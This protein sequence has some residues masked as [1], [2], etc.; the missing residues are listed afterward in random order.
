MLNLIIEKIFMNNYFKFLGFLFIFGTT[1]AIKLDDLNFSQLIDAVDQIESPDDLCKIL[2]LQTYF[3]MHILDKI[4][5]DCKYESNYY[6]FD[7]NFHPEDK[8]E[9]K[10]GWQESLIVLMNLIQFLDANNYCQ[11]E[12]LETRISTINEV[13]KGLIL[14]T[15]LLSDLTCIEPEVLTNS[16]NSSH[17]KLLDEYIIKLE[18]PE[19]AKELLKYNFSA[20]DNLKYLLKDLIEVID[21]D[22]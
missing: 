19:V 3:A 10:G 21:L 6:I 12:D 16:E 22:I 11:E 8:M 2:K 5:F 17:T 20:L 14:V 1:Q 7:P 18:D 9:L 13:K 4:D 15:L